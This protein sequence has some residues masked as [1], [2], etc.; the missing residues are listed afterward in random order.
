MRADR[1]EHQAMKTYTTAEAIAVAEHLES[2]K[3]SARLDIR[4]SDLIRS[5]VAE[6]DEANA[7]YG[8]ESAS[9]AGRRYCTCV[10]GVGICSKCR[11][12]KAQAPYRK[13]VPPVRKKMTIEEENDL[14]CT[15]FLGWTYESNPMYPGQPYQYGKHVYAPQAFLDR[16][17]SGLIL[18]KFEYLRVDYRL[19]YWTTASGIHYGCSVRMDGETYEFECDGVAECIRAAALKLIEVVK[20]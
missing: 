8:N 7:P 11:R 19:R 17:S 4:I 14:I 9:D 5:L 2:E 18:D 10:G 6:R 20:R 1:P 15:H 16:E 12:E 3:S 13:E